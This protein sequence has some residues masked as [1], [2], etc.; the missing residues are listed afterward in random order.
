MKFL[1]VDLF[2]KIK[3]I[4]GYLYWNFKGV[5]V[6]DSSYVSMKANLIKCSVFGKSMILD[7]AIIGAHSYLTDAYVQHA[8]IG[9][10]CS[11]APGVKIGLEEHDTE[12]FSTHPSNYDSKSFVQSKGRVLIGDHIWLGANS[13]ILQGVKIGNHAVIAAGAVVTK[14]VPNGEIWGGVPAKFLKT[15]NS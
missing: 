10:Y 8:T 4:Q 7:E 3:R 9:S 12:N 6:S 2:N 13:I 15:R 14:D 1:V 11:I 5:R